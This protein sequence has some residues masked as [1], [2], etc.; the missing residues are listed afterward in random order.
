MGPFLSHHAPEEASHE[1]KPI[2]STPAAPPPPALSSND[3]AVLELKV[4]R[5]KLKRSKTKLD[6]DRAQYQARAKALLQQGRKD[7]ALTLLKV[8]KYKDKQFLQVEGQLDNV[9]QTLASVLSAEMTVKVMRTLEQGTAALKRLNEEMP[10]ERVEALMEETAEAIA[11]QQEVSAVLSKGL[12]PA[13]AESVDEELEELQREVDGE[14]K[15]QLPKAP[16]TV[17]KAREGVHTS[18]RGEEQ[19]RRELV[20]S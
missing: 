15:V 11:Y 16:T 7:E 17:P 9:N 12:N 2:V 10:I 8:K 1:R 14:P 18:E 20:P 6:K 3:K 19:P 4:A 5:N 13:E